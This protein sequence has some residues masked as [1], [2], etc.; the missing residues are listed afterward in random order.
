MRTC[1]CLGVVLHAERRAI[2]QTQTFDNIVIEAHMAHLGATVG[3][4]EGAIAW[5]VDRETVIVSRDLY[6][7]GAKVHDRLIDAAV[8]VAQLVGTKPERTTENL[9]AEAD[10]E[11]RDACLENR[12]HHGDGVSRGCR[13]TR[14]IG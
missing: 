6:L 2:E 7:A 4:V 12:L 8:A 5:G 14:T 10:T 3:G 11:Y 1:R 13:I 9:V